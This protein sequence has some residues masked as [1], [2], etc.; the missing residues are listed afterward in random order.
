MARA[1]IWRRK[2]RAALAS[3]RKPASTSIW[4]RKLP[5][6]TSIAT[7]KMLS[8]TF[9][10]AGDIPGAASFD[11]EGD[12]LKDV[13]LVSADFSGTNFPST[14]TLMIARQNADGTFPSQVTTVPLNAPLPGG[15][16]RAV[17][18]D[19][20]HDGKL[21]VAFIDGLPGSAKNPPSGSSAVWVAL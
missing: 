11:V 1:E 19:F 10:A 5:G 2:S 7:A 14:I 6:R 16:T 8:I 17:A 4:L 9:N 18:G 13:V 15:L 3:S 21:D 20:N 12:G